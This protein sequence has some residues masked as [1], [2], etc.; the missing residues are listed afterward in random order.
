MLGN[1]KIARNIGEKNKWR[2]N[3]LYV[4]ERD[5]TVANSIILDGTVYNYLSR[6]ESLIHF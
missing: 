2:K 1:A 6:G 3:V 4:T 5:V